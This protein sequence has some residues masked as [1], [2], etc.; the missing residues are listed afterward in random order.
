MLV[1]LALTEDAGRT[2]SEIADLS[3]LKSGTVSSIRRRLVES[4]AISFV[5]VPQLSKLGCEIIGFHRGPT[6]PGV[7]SGTKAREYMNFTRGSPQVFFAMK[8]GNQVVFY[9]ALKNIAEYDGFVQN[10]VRFFGGEKSRLK[11][12]LSNSLFPCSLTRLTA[13]PRFAHIVHTHFGLDV[14]PP[15]VRYPEMASVETPDFTPAERKTL[16]AVVE[17]PTSS[18]RTVASIVK[19]SR[20]AVTRI[21]N[22][23]YDEGILTT[24]CI[25]H[26]QSWG[27]EIYLVG[28]PRYNMEIPWEKRLRSQPGEVN[29]LSFFTLS[30]ADEGVGNYMTAKFSTYTDKSS[31]IMMWYHRHG[32]FDEELELLL[33]PL[34]RTVCL[35]N[36]DFGPAVRSLL[37]EK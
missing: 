26:L 28:H 1:I 24:V 19:L 23:L 33:F 14:P 11:A 10:H 34:E 15:E 17:N 20:Q 32:L 30:K 13:V 29:N 8:G 7:D 22:K 4:G 36:F 3:G 2:D 12:K 6:N 5:V 35:R 21:R 27:F 31:E 37:A 18:D 25:P 9:T 16:M